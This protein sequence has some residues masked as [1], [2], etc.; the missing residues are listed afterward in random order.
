M[1]INICDSCGKKMREKEIV[2]TQFKRDHVLKYLSICPDCFNE[3][4]KKAKAIQEAQEH[5]E[6]ATE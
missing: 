6:G 1:I 5:G 4:L 2:T 3:I